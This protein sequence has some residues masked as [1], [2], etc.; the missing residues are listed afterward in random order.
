MK[1][2]ETRS[3]E[4]V[5]Q[6]RENTQKY[7]EALITENERL[8]SLVND[9]E[10]QRQKTDRRLGIA[11]SEL[12]RVESERQKL[13]ERIDQIEV[14]SQDLLGQFQEI[15]RQNSD[16]A[17]LYVASYRLHE[18]IK[19]SEVIAVIEE[20]V[21]NMIGSE[22]LAIFELDDESGKLKLVD[23]LG[24]NPEDLERVTLNESRI[25]GAT[26]VL[27]EV[28]ETGQRYVVDSG[29]GKALEKNSGLTACVPLILDSHVI[30]AIAVF[31]L[32]DQKESKLAPLDFE[33]FDL[34]ATHAASALYCSERALGK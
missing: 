8:R 2:D 23:S 5:L 10:E 18:T 14:E 34:L 7:I 32:L 19:R 33:L 24:I 31:R 27:Q 13:A 15:E 17:S 30:G 26:G 3:E 28:V 1:K 4:Y 29:D 11:E 22:E 12:G 16:L 25:E 21:V 9:L 6:V 20:I